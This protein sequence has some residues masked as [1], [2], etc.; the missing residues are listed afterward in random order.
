M[1][2]EGVGTLLGAFM[3]VGI[4]S[5]PWYA[6]DVPPDEVVIVVGPVAKE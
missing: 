5:L 6:A 1:L 4:V 2:K 3:T